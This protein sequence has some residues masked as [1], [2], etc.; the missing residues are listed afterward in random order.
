[1][2]SKLLQMI[3][4][5]MPFFYKKLPKKNLLQSLVTFWWQKKVVKNGITE[6]IICKSFEVMKSYI[7]ILSVDCNTH[8]H[9]YTLIKKKLFFESGEFLLELPPPFRRFFQKR[10]GCSRSHPYFL[11]AQFE[12]TAPLLF[13]RRRKNFGVFLYKRPFFFSIGKRQM[14]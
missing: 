4:S 10:R 7:I 1:M 3:T 13:C 11:S 2:T 5:V 12:L 8:L 14:G 9:T 6:V